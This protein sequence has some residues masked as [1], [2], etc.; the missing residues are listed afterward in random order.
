MI[1]EPDRNHLLA[2][3]L[4]ARPHMIPGEAQIV[5]RPG[6]GRGL[7]FDSV[8][9]ERQRRD[10]RPAPIA[11]E[12]DLELGPDAG[13]LG[14]DIAES[15]M[16]P[17]QSRRER[18]AGHA[19]DLLAVLEDGIAVSNGAGTVDFQTYQLPTHARGIYFYERVLADE[20]LIELHSPS[21]SHFIRVCRRIHVVAVEQVARFG[22]Q[23]LARRDAVRLDPQRLPR[24]EQRVPHPGRAVAV[25]HD[26][27]AAFAGVAGTTD[28]DRH[29][30]MLGMDRRLQQPV[31]L[32]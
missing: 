22:P 7:V 9:A 4:E 24:R 31:V 16:A 18:P 12:L 27:V 17:G 19:P 14:R 15:E 3:V 10:T 8:F 26:L 30:G 1:R 21:E 29:F 23:A 13:V 11:V 20:I 2:A 25:D 5:W 6:E 32:Q 28:D